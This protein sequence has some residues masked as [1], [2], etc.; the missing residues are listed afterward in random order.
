M[1]LPA[2]SVALALPAGWNGPVSEHL[3]LPATVV[4]VMFGAVLGVGAI[5]MLSSM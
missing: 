1:T 3:S 5:G 2:P 4:T